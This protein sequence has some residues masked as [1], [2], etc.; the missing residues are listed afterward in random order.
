MTLCLYVYCA[1]SVVWLCDPVDP[2]P[3]GSSVHGIFQAR[4]LEWVALP[5]SRA[6]SQPR[7]WTHI[8]CISW[9]WQTDSLPL[10]HLGSPSVYHSESAEVQKFAKQMLCGP[11]Q[12]NRASLVAQIVKKLPSVWET[13]LC[14]LDRGDPLEKGMTTHA[15]ILV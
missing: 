10:Y 1:G 3:P 2:S 13:Q 12:A 8:S 4:V 15:S 14:S 5:F 6:S 9:H 7:D 11:V